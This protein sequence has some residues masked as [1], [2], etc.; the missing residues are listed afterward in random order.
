MPP[1]LLS[2]VK[3]HSF[4]KMEPGVIQFK[5]FRCDEVSDGSSNL[6]VFANCPYGKVI[7]INVEDSFRFTCTEDADKCFGGCHFGG[8]TTDKLL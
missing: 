5:S 3:I 8:T 4:K 1:K 2:N 7:F 6:G